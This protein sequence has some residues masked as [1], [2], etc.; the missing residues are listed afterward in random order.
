MVHHFHIAQSM[1]HWINP[2]LRVWLTLV[3]FTLV[4]FDFLDSVITSLHMEIICDAK[5][6]HW[7]ERKENLYG[8]K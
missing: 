1:T 7:Q 3:K 5:Y 4:N 6:W 2:E 8:Q